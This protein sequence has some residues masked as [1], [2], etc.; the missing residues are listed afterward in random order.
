MGELLLLMGLFDMDF[1]LLDFKS[2]TNSTRQQPDPT[3]KKDKII[4]QPMVDK[5]LFSGPWNLKTA[6]YYLQF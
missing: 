4:Y 2:N 6:P 3:H 1:R 5:L